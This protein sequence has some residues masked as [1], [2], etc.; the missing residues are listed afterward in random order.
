MILR[1]VET[2]QRNNPN[3]SHSTTFRVFFNKMDMK[4]KHGIIYFKSYKKLHTTQ[5]TFIKTSVFKLHCT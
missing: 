3:S 1:V 5:R 4:D 2:T